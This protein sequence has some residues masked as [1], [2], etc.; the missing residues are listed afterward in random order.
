[1]HLKTTLTHLLLHVTGAAGTGEEAPN[2]LMGDH[3][4]KFWA[5]YGQSIIKASTRY[6]KLGKTSVLGETYGLECVW[7]V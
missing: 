4:L 6:V 2:V 3:T 5:L 7:K 1:M